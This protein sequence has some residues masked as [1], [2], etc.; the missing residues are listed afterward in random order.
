MIYV[1]LADGFE[2]VEALTPV[3]LLRRAGI[4]VYTVGITGKNVTG[5]HGIT[6]IA[7]ITPD[8]AVTEK[9]EG[10]ILPGGMPGTVNLE[11]D[12][13]VQQ[14]IDYA[15]GNDLVIGA[16][17]AAPSVL[18]HKGL[19]RGRRA[20]CFPGFENELE[21]ADIITDSPAVIDGKI[22]TAWGA[23]GAVDFGLALLSLIKGKEAAEK[24]RKSFK[25]GK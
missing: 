9:L 10:I 12:A 13:Y 16:I 5:S 23:G 18:G 8:E 11:N 21:A 15:A 22:V 1:F 6:V 7:D 24:M 20:T 3:D 4:D 17:C 19:L 2:E 25:Y 14:F